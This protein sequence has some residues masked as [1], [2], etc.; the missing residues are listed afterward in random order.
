MNRYVRG[1]EDL[2]DLCSDMS[3][4][5]KERLRFCINK[6]FELGSRAI[7][8]GKKVVS[9]KQVDEIESFIKTMKSS[10]EEYEGFY[11]EVLNEIESEIQFLG[12]IFI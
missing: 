9:K 6:Q 5:F 2:F 7:I 8:Y 3:E 11:N 4:V 12:V 1:D 10:V